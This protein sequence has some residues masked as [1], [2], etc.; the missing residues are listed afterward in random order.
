MCISVCVVQETLLS[1][2][3]MKDWHKICSSPFPLYP[4][5]FLL[6][7]VFLLCIPETRRL[8]ALLSLSL[9]FCLF[10]W[11]SFPQIWAEEK[12]GV[13]HQSSFIKARSQ[14]INFP[15]RGGEGGGAGC[16][17]KKIP[18]LDN[19]MIEEWFMPSVLLEGVAG[20]LFHW[21]KKLSNCDLE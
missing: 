9:F 4:P 16:G 18:N 8:E 20:F 12:Q 10:K 1:Q 13:A 15:G 17:R 11:A 21:V 6:L 3:N 2:G 5:L 7:S 19:M 14:T